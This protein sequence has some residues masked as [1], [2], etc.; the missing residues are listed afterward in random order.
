MQVFKNSGAQEVIV[1]SVQIE[2]HGSVSR[3]RQIGPNLAYRLSLLEI[4]YLLGNWKIVYAYQPDERAMSIAQFRTLLTK[5]GS[6]V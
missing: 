1:S 3:L 2:L 5:F 6:V 4:S